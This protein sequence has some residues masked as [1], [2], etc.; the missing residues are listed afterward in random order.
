MNVGTIGA[1]IVGRRSNRI[2]IAPESDRRLNVEPLTMQP[3]SREVVRYA[4]DRA[5]EGATAADIAAELRAMGVP[6]FRG[7]ERDVFKQRHRVRMWLDNPDQYCPWDDPIA[8]ERA[9][10]GDAEVYRRMT[11]WERRR[12]VDSLEA[13]FAVDKDEAIAIRALLGLSR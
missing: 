5:E 3:L 10:Q 9:L 11:P 12:V 8:L 4:Y 2:A 1:A 13:H 6:G 7:R